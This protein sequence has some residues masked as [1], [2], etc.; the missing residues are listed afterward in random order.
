MKAATETSSSSSSDHCLSSVVSSIAL[1]AAILEE[2]G[3]DD[4]LRPVYWRISSAH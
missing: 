1:V 4:V 2:D 3:V